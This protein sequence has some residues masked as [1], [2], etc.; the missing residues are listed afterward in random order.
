MVG[1]DAHGA[2]ERLALLHEG[3]EDLL[4][5]FHLQRVLL[6]ALVVD[7]LERLA[8]VCEVPRVDADL[9]ERLGHADSHLRREVH[10]CHQGGV[11]PILEQ[12]LADL[13]ARVG[14]HHALHRDAHQVRASIGASLHLLHRRLDVAG[15]G[16]GHGLQGDGVLASDGHLPNPDGSCGATLGDVVLFA[17]DAGGNHQLRHQQN[18]IVGG[19]LHDVHLPAAGRLGRARDRGGDSYGGDRVAP[20]PHLGRHLKRGSGNH[21]A[22]HLA[23]QKECVQRC[24][25]L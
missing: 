15:V 22:L 3:G 11:V 23:Q 5:P 10:I 14:L 17:I 21:G 9:L 2:V 1:A 12:L 6:G 8:A 24:P 18:L 4:A 25:R 16:S 19:R 7:L 20:G 13:V